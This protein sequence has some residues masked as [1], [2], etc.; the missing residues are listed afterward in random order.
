MCRP[1]LL[2][3]KLTSRHQLAPFIGQAVVLVLATWAVLSALA[4]TV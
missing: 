2:P 1:G 4:M 3:F